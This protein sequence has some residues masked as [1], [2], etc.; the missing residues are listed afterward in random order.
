M[1][2]YGEKV[3]TQTEEMARASVRRPLT[4]RKKAVAWRSRGKCA[5]NCFSIFYMAVFSAPFLLR[6]PLF[7]N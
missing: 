2:Q 7:H 6:E 3:I 1:Y 5:L 4:N